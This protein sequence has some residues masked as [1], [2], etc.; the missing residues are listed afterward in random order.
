MFRREVLPIDKIVNMFLRQN[1]L[2]TPLLQKRLV[3]AWDSMAGK[4][5]ARYT[6]DKFI[7]N[8][9]LYVKISSPAMRSDLSMIRTELVNKLNQH[10][11]AR[12]I[13]D[14]KFF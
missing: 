5:I 3:D 13:I 4:T 9:V 12:I 1:G 2:E 14:I 6:E 8:Q 11:G 10:V 7:R